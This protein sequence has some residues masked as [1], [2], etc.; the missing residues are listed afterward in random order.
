MSKVC[1]MLIVA[2][3]G[4]AL[5]ALA[6][7]FETSARGFASSF[8]SASRIMSHVVSAALMANLVKNAATGTLSGA[9]AAVMI[10][11]PEN[12]DE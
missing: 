7:P 2:N 4:M 1:P 3:S 11:P 12:A 8:F 6:S 5:T 9:Q 10:E